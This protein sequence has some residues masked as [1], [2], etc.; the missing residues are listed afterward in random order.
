MELKALT[1]LDWEI[2]AQLL[3]DGKIKQTYL[4]PD[5]AKTEDAFPLFRHL[6]ELSQ[7]S[8]HF[9]RGIWAEEGLV[10]FCNDVERLNGSIELGYVIHPEHWGKGYASGALKLAVKE[11]FALGYREVTAGAFEENIASIR[12]MEKAGMKRLAKADEIEYRGKVHRCVYYAVE[13]MV[14]AI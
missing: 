5:F 4:L 8:R 9:V 2:M 3:T 11:L 7:D 13:N 6:L 1:E 14:A 12:V 10:G